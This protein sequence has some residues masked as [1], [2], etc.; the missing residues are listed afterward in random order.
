MSA[1]AVE[2]H[3]G[4][5]DWQIK[6]SAS[7]GAVVMGYANPRWNSPKALFL[8]MLEP[9]RHRDETMS[10]AA[11]RGT[12][13]EAGLIDRW[14]YEHPE[15]IDRHGGEKRYDR[16]VDGFPF[17]ATPDD[18]CRIPTGGTYLGVEDSRIGIE[19]KTVGSHAPDLDEWGEPGTDVIPRKYL[20]QVLFQQYMSGIRRTAVIKAGPYIDDFHTY[21]VDYNERAAEDIIARCVRFMQCVELELPPPNDGAPATWA[22]VK[23]HNPDIIRDALGEDWPISL[24]L[25]LEYS[26]AVQSFAT[27]EARLLKAKSDTFEAMGK[28]RRAIVELPAEIGKNG[29]PKKPRV[30]T[31][32]RRQGTKGGGVTLIAPTK[33]VDLAELRALRD[34]ATEPAN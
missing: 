10:T 8:S 16:V 24:D 17:V 2:R 4:T 18:E 33:P 29:K 6:M 21:W 19:C 30:L 25:A 31:I 20:V 13:L 11:V 26:D 12:F 27:A 7:K 14:F 5:L 32:A 28:A 23:R 34:A 22:A 3:V 9:E 15:A 1:P